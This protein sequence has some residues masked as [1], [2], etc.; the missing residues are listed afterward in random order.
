MKAKK[1]TVIPFVV[2]SFRTLLELFGKEHQEE[3]PRQIE[4]IALK[5]N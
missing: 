5:I 1:V 2:G 4:I 3:V